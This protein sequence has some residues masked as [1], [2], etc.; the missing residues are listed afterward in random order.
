MEFKVGK[1]KKIKS[2]V[3]VCRNNIFRVPDDSQ[4]TV[5]RVLSNGTIKQKYKEKSDL[6][7]SK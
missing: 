2:N 7:M 4:K 3:C 1:K 6:I 5:E